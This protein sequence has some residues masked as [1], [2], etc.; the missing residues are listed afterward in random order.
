VTDKIH[1]ALKKLDNMKLFSLYII[2]SFTVF[3]SF[4]WSQVFDDEQISQIQDQIDLDLKNT[5]PNF[6]Q[7][8][9][10][11]KKNQLSIVLNSIAN[12]V[13]NRQWL[14]PSGPEWPILDWTKVDKIDSFFK[15][16]F[17]VVNTVGVVAQ[18]N[19]D[20][21]RFA[22]AASLLS[23][24]S[25][26]GEPWFQSWLREISKGNDSNLKRLVFISVNDLGEDYLNALDAESGEQLV[27]DW[28]AW[29]QAY[30]QSNKLGK[31]ILLK[32]MTR[33]ALI[34]DNWEKLKEIHLSVFNGN[35]DELKAIALVKGDNG[36]GQEIVTEWKEI[37]KNSTNAKL[38][39]LA[40]EVLDRQ[41][42]EIE[43]AE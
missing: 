11:E 3:S 5:H 8:T 31:A 19:K 13:L 40:Q 37:A 32:S 9:D 18:S 34:T 24:I 30:D 21:A 41:Q 22:Y 26:L 28:N 39:K 29:K 4:L 15:D 1:P 6:E 16:Q 17:E 33:L 36:I 38:K 10:V 2:F 20:A 14:H 23:R 43:K 27:V 42:I 25:T 7:S 35:D 12:N